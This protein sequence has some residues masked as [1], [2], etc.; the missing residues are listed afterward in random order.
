MAVGWSKDGEVQEQIDST[1]KEALDR[2]RREAPRGESL[3]SCEV[4][5]EAISRAR[6]EALPGVRRCV[7]CQTMREEGLI[8]T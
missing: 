4:C 5:S 8:G 3:E 7:R 2:V 6:R 1:V